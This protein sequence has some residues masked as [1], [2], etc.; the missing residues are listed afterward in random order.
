MLKFVYSLF[1]VIFISACGVDTSSSPM[2]N[3]LDNDGTGINTPVDTDPNPDT[4]TTDTN[5]TD[6]TDTNTTDTTD[7][8]T[9]DGDVVVPGDTDTNT[10]EPDIESYFDTVGAI[11]DAD[12]CNPTGF[13]IASDASYNGSQIGEN[14]ASSFIIV[15][16]GLVIRSEYVSSDTPS[17]WVTLFYKR[18]PDASQFNLQG[19]TSYKMEDVFYLS[20][21]L[22]WSDESI[23]DVD[24]RMYLQ[25]NKFEKPYCYRLDLNNTVGSR[26][27]VQKVYR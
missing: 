26:I 18:F 14:G 17:T 25:S 7:T 4:N 3:I 24:N 22:A 2:G 21:D 13:R 15:D 9:T 27:G 12:A 16:Q 8:N 10:T 19:V 1:I 6:T 5:T 20:Y 23:P 11:F